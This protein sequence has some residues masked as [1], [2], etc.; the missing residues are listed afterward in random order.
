MPDSR[1]V[2]VGTLWVPGTFN[3]KPVEAFMPGRDGIVG[4]AEK[5]SSILGQTP[6]HEPVI[7]HADLKILKLEGEEGERSDVSRDDLLPFGNPDLSWWY[8]KMLL[9]QPGKS[10]PSDEHLGRLGQMGLWMQ[11]PQQEPLH[12]RAQYNWET[13][14]NLGCVPQGPFSWNA[15]TRFVVI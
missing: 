1:L 12:I 2:Q 3:F 15:G 8:L 4:V 13:G 14:H 5:L 10:W 11:M 6:I 9:L 7:Y